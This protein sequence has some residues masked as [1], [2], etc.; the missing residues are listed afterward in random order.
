LLTVKFKLKGTGPKIQCLFYFINKLRMDADYGGLLVSVISIG[1][2]Y[3]F[4]SVS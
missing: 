4:V 3:A 1:V 2:Y